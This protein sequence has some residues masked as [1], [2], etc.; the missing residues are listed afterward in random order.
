MSEAG[1]IAFLFRQTALAALFNSKILFC[2]Q[3]FDE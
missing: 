2:A 3:V 1:A